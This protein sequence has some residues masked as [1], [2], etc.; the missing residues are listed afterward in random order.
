MLKG[1]NFAQVSWLALAMIAAPA[2]AQEARTVVQLDSGWRFF[3]GDSPD[4]VA[5][6]FADAA[7]EQV[8][9]PHTWNRVGYY[10]HDL[11]GS[12]TAASVKKR[13][14]VGWYRLHFAAPVGSA[15]KRQWLEFDAASRV[16]KVWLNGQYLGEHRGG[17][18][19]FRFDATAAMRAQ[20]IGRASCRE[21]V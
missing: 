15:G 9:V 12:N 14:G 5:P 17:F 10:R 3:D 7:W 13:Q 2:C 11:G 6:D 21:R 4:A 8:S 1:G 18:S 19:R 20:E 16:A